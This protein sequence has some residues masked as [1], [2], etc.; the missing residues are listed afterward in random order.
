MHDTKMIYSQIPRD[1]LD[2]VQVSDCSVG[3]RRVQIQEVAHKT[4]ARSWLPSEKSPKKR[5][6]LCLKVPANSRLRAERAEPIRALL[7]NG[8]GAMLSDSI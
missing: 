6:R 7:T 1:M 3:Q 5:E 8:F 2:T 4:N